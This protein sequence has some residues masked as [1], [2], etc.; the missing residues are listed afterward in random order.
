MIITNELINSF[1]DFYKARGRTD[2]TIERFKR[3]FTR[4]YLWLKENKEDWIV[5]VEDLSIASIEQW[6]F[7]VSQ[8]EVPKTSRYY[9]KEG[10]LASKTIQW[11]IQVIKNFLHFVNYVYGIGVNANVIETPKA[12]SKRMDYFTEEEIKMIIKRV[13]ENEKNE[14]N[15]TRLI[16]VILIGF[17]AWL[18]LQEI[19][20]LKTNEILENVHRLKGK[21]WKWRYVYFNNEIHY[22]TQKY[23]K[24]RQQPI[25]QTGKSYTPK[26]D[27]IIISHSARNFWGKFQKTSLC[28]I[29]KKVSDKLNLGKELSC[30]TLRH[31]FATYLLNRGVDLSK[32]QHLLGHSKLET[33]ATYLHESWERLKI[34]HEWVFCENITF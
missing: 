16:L 17:T 3:D 20:N 34:I 33:T 5:A 28:E 22:Y 32:I 14:L 26:S 9:W 2:K 29:F 24:L 13:K 21:G 18:R 31:S 8:Q 19:L 7:I 1:L 15:Q 27:Y 11:K 30:H 23:L 12:K 25:E 6:R 4:Y 10:H